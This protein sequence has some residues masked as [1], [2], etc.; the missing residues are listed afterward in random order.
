[1]ARQV[2]GFG[3]R[4]GDASAKGEQAIGRLFSPEFRNRLDGIVTFKPLT[5]MIM[6]RVVEKYID[7]LRGQLSHKK[8]LITLTDDAR[9]WLSEK[10]FDPL[11]GARPLARLIQT[12]IKDV[13]TDEIMFGRLSKGGDV[14]IGLR[15]GR[16]DFRY[17]SALPTEGQNA[18]QSKKSS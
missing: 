7:E 5:T 1:M 16:I 8:V 4:T 12:E 3:D 2:V 11:F 10:G 13:L 14:L 15:D 6:R 18:V 17:S 9:D